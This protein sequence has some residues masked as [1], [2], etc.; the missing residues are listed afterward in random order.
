MRARYDRYRRRR[1]ELSYITSSAA[2]YGFASSD[3]DKV[4]FR[5]PV[6]GAVAAGDLADLALDLEQTLLHLYQAGLGSV[7]NPVRQLVDDLLPTV[8]YVAEVL[9]DFDRLVK[10]LEERD[11]QVETLTESVSDTGKHLSQQVDRVAELEEELASVRTQLESFR[12]VSRFH[13]AFTQVLYQAEKRGT[14]RR[15]TV[16]RWLDMARALADRRARR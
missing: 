13:D 14:V 9:T 12:E 11:Q 2:G 16:S 1:D 4:Q 15:G 3:Q 8:T 5:L 10:A 7:V 6:P